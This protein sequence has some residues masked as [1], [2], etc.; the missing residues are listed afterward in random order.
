[1]FWAALKA[2]S[3]SGTCAAVGNPA[4]RLAYSSAK[5]SRHILE[6]HWLGFSMSILILAR[7]IDR[8]CNNSDVSSGAITGSSPS[9][10]RY[11]VAV[12]LLPLLRCVWFL[13]ASC[14]SWIRVP[15][16][17]TRLLSTCMHGWLPGACWASVWFLAAV[18][19]MSRASSSGDR[20]CSVF[21][22]A[23]TS[24]TGASLVLGELAGT[25][26]VECTR[27]PSKKQMPGSGVILVSGQR[28]KT[29]PVRALYNPDGRHMLAGSCG[30]RRM[31]SAHGSC[32]AGI[33]LW[34][35]LAC[36]CRSLSRFPFIQ[37]R[38]DTRT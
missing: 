24:H 27:H 7:A 21:C 31:I 14:A 10:G 2:G 35:T 32:C 4:V 8:Q 37:F 20:D 33:H 34:P 5:N 12:A 16:W 17:V 3:R 6:T 26:N 11:C 9:F 23:S 28:A 15:C 29:R 30:W 22:G 38:S 19:R 36:A 1:M 25:T 13:A 18:A